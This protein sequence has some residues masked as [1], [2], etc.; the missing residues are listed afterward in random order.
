MFARTDR[1]ILR[2]GWIEDSAELATAIG[3]EAVVGNLSRVPWPYGLED[4]E[5]WLAHPQDAQRPQ[6]LIFARTA[7]DPQLVG[8]IGIT[9]LDCRR[10]GR[11]ELGYWIAQPHWGRGYATEAARAVLDMAFW[12]LRLDRI[13]AG[14]FPDN[15]GSARVL[16]KLGFIPRGNRML[17]RSGARP[18]IEP[19]CWY[20]LDAA[21]WTGVGRRLVA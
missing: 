9:D 11:A 14:H 12:S 2:P 10:D 8:G 16:A 7:G 21:S 6:L 3:D 4:A 17:H 1:M 19:C 18:Q 15:Q 20:D 13:E 5:A